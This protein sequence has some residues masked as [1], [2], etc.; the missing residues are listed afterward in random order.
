MLILAVIV[1]CVLSI[2]GLRFLVFNKSAEKV[3]QENVGSADSQ[4]I[5]VKKYAQADVMRH[6]DTFI[7]FGAV[8]A[9]GLV[10]ASF[11]LKDEP[12][13]ETIAVTFD[14]D[15]EFEVEVPPTF[16]EPTPP[17]PPPP[18]QI[19]VVEDDEIIKE[20]PKFEIREIDVE[21]AIAPPAPV[22]EEVVVEDEIFKVV[23]QMPEFPGGQAALMQFL[24]KI[25]Y[26]PFARENDLEGTVYV[27]FV[28]DKSGK[29][30]DAV[31]ARSSGHKILDDAALSHVRT[32]PSW[33]PGKQRGKPVRVQYVVPIKFKLG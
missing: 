14:A 8:F 13:V 6:S 1:L 3:M 21:E 15:E 23:E 12:E 24:G 5:F 32:M 7:L 2:V 11:T 19:E 26:P 9:L 28:I 22:V 27:Q 10:L 16:R 29:I 18:P 25:T 30:T 4:S 17:P 33:A 31:I 20:Q